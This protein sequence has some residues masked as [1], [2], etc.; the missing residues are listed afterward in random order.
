M[1]CE[2]WKDI[3]GYEGLYQV[4][5][6]GRVKSLNYGRTRTAKVL[7]NKRIG[8]GYYGVNLYLSPGHPVTHSIHRLVALAYLPNPQGLPQ[9]NHLDEDKSNN[10][11]DNLEWC[12]SKRNVN[13]G[14]CLQ[15]AAKSKQKPV[16]Q[17]KDGKIIRV[18]QSGVEAGQHGFIPTKIAQCC[19]GKRNS[20]LGYEWRYAT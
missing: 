20:H 8:H 5:N 12:T 19:Q 15:R 18:W 11:V 7:V 3:V 9:V 1:K 14:T 6:L 4:S 2:E 13:Y 10:D 16:A 17:I